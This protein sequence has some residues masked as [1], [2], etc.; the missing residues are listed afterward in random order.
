MKFDLLTAV[1]GKYSSSQDDDYGYD[2]H[3]SNRASAAEVNGAAIISCD[4]VKNLTARWDSIVH[5]DW[6]LLPRLRVLPDVVDEVRA[7]GRGRLC[8]QCAGH[9]SHDFFPFLAQRT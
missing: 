8:V 9:H 4:T 6:L 1:F 2:S 3:L 7:G 5:K